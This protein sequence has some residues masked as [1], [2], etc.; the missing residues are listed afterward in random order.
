MAVAVSNDDK[1]LKCHVPV[2][3]PVPTSLPPRVSA[4]QS[5]TNATLSTF[6]GWSVWLMARRP[7]GSS[8]VSPYTSTNV[9]SPTQPFS[10]RAI[11]E[12]TAFSPFTAFAQSKMSAVSELSAIHQPRYRA[13]F[14]GRLAAYEIAISARSANLA[15][16][17]APSQSLAPEEAKFHLVDGHRVRSLLTKRPIPHVFSHDCLRSTEPEW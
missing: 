3:V 6:S 13:I 2:V 4:S 5:F 11:A 7:G 16:L 9:T 15:G 14:T 17:F 10:R 8:G 1:A 12:C